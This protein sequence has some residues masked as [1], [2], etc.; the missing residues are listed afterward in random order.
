MRPFKYLKIAGSFLIGSSGEGLLPFALVC[1]FLVMA[2]G[3]AGPLQ[4]AY[5]PKAPDKS[6]KSEMIKAPVTVFIEPAIDQREKKAADPRRIGR[7][8][9]VVSDMNAGDLVISEDVEQLVR[10]ALVAEF[11]SA[12]FVVMT[13]GEAKEADFVL[14]SGVK[15]LRLDVGPRDSVSVVI[16]ASLEETVTDKPIWS[17]DGV[18]KG[19]RF[20]G[21]SGN[22]GRLC[23]ISLSR[24]QRP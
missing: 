15:D 4:V 6:D 12:G 20:A 7:I 21:V 23:G 22:S 17:G 9:A 11:K 14:R 8:D 18:E 16:A 1:I 24:C 10:R 13:E 3:C 5:S 2:A 19:D